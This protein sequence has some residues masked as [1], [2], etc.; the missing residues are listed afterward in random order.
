MEGHEHGEAAEVTTG[1]HC[2]ILLGLQHSATSVRPR[3]AVQLGLPIHTATGTIIRLGDKH[4]A[5]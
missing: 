1:A 3:S 4:T 5:L 2:V